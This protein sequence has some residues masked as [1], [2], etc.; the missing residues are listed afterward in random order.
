MNLWGKRIAAVGVAIAVQA[1]LFSC[2]SGPR[3]PAKGTPAFDWQLAQERY[4]A[5]DYL[6]T[7]EALER[8]VATDNEFAAQA[9]PW[10][11]VMTS[12]MARGYME[13]AD[14]FEGGARIN[15]AD[16]TTFRR[17]MSQNRNEAGRMAL[18]FAEA[19]GA[20]QAR[21]ED[22]VVLAFP[23]PTG[24]AAPVGML[25][26][27]GNG[28]LPPQTEIDA[29]L[30]AAMRRAV[31]LNTCSAAGSPDDTAKAQEIFKAGEVKLP[32]AD[33][34]LA[35]AGAMHDTAQVY[36]RNKLD[37]PQKMEI[38]CTRAQEALQNVPESKERKE[39]LAKI[40][41]TLKKAK[42]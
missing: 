26:K 38:F 28:M 23:F 1:I 16:P 42:S 39:L 7:I 37:D 14:Y 20:F 24:S 32:R 15:K 13:V 35:M 17:Q 27:V 34:I 41:A 6:R 11:L 25:V 22:P 3:P 30:R 29:G 21:T 31:L 8:I 10:L 2:A 33:F 18:R 5:G 9:T 36:S 12:G 4:A 19:F 40:Q